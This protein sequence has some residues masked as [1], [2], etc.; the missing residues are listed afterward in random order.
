MLHITRQS[1]ADVHILALSG[2]LEPGNS[3]QLRTE[4]SSLT[5]ARA[6]RI[7]LDMKGLHSI[8][9]SG[10]AT[11]LEALAS[12]W[13][14]GGEIKLIRVGTRVRGV[15]DIFRLGDVLL[16]PLARARPASGN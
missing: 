14:Y 15:I 1:S 12:A 9:S 13:D 7:V 6:R 16:G 8:D 10:L 5:A 11:L 3:A 2:R 4:L